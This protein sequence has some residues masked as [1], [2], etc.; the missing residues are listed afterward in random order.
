MELCGELY[1]L[2]VLCVCVCVCVCACV[3]ACVRACGGGAAVLKRL[4][5]PSDFHIPFPSVVPFA[6]S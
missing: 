4:A 5:M 6:H 1:T 2:P 3:R